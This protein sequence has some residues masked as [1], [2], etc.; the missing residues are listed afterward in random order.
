[1]SRRLHGINYRVLTSLVVVGLPVLLLA[2]YLV[3][4]N[5]RARL[6]DAFGLK[7]AQRAEQSASA[8]DAY[9]YRRVV[10]V[11]LLGRI[12]QIR[13]EAVR[14]S[15]RPP[16]ARAD[17]E[18]DK[19]FAAHDIKRPAVASLLATE[20][21]KYFAD[22]TRQDPVYREILLT[23]LGGRLVAAS[24]LT[25]DYTQADEDWWK[26]VMLDPSRGESTVSDVRW[27]DSAH[28]FAMEIAVP[29]PGL[30]ERPAGVLK[31]VADIREMLP[32]VA[33]MDLGDAGDAMVVRRNGSIVF[34]RRSV[35]PS[36]RFFAADRLRERLASATASAEPSRL[37]F[38]APADDGQQQI[39]GVATSQLSSTYPHLPWVVV[40][41]QSESE[42]LA[43]VQTQ[44]RSLMLVLALTGLCVLG[45]ALWFSIR[46]AAKPFETDM[47]LVPH[48]RIARVAEEESV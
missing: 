46:L 45:L 13:A 39:V 29:V 11:S 28:T 14:G 10:D 31:V 25:S 17:A 30:D 48:P 35:Q 7:L 20:T 42:L 12:P 26:R 41:W 16:D 44:F 22:I 6:R 18:M 38:S 1:M 3:L 37:F 9:V 4:A 5:G 33:G 21:S 24:N 2:S 32:S 23:D 15:S 27:D 8:I 40:T 19:A 47:D 43:P 36:T 34:S